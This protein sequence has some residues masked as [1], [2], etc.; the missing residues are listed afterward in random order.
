MAKN[1]RQN[2]AQGFLAKYSELALKPE[3][4]VTNLNLGDRGDLR[5]GV[6][7]L[8]RGKTVNDYFQIVDGLME[9]YVKAEGDGAEQERL[10]ELSSLIMAIGEEDLGID[11][12]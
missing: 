6:T 3:V 5:M 2:A 12:S 10:H 11:W 1:E 8:L 4:H 7:S 9:A